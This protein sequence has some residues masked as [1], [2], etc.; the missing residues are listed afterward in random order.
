MQPGQGGGRGSSGGRAGPRSLHL[1][2]VQEPRGSGLVSGTT[3]VVPTSSLILLGAGFSRRH[4]ARQGGTIVAQHVSA[5]NRAG[6]F[7]EPALAGGTMPVA[8][9]ECRLLK[10][11]LHS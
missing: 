7:P 9:E 11:A 5:G 6:N 4:S 8:T 1:S 10:Q 3:S 2:E